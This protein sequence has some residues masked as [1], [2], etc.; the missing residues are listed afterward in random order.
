[1]KKLPNSRPSHLILMALALALSGIHCATNSPTEDLIISGGTIY[2]MD[3]ERPT[4]EAMLIRGGKVVFFGTEAGALTWTGEKAQRININGGIVIPGLIDAHAHVEGVGKLFSQLDLVG[5]SSS[6]EIRD[7]VIEALATTPKGAWLQG[8]GWDQNDWTEKTFPTFADLTETNSHPVYLRRI[9]GHACWVNRRALEICGIDS[10]TQDPP[11]GRIVRDTNGAPTGI[12]VD[13]AIDLISK[14]LENPS[15]AERRNWV[16]TGIREC[17]RLGLVGVHDA[18]V[19]S[20]GLAIY[21]DLAQN[22]SLTLRINAMLSSTETALLDSYLPKGPTTEANGFVNIRSIKIYAD[23][24]LGSRG[25]WLLEPYSDRPELSGLALTAPDSVLALTERAVDAG[26]QV[27]THAIGDRGVRETLDS[28]EETL[29]KT[30]ASD[31]RL[32]I[33][34]SQ[35]ISESDIP[36]FAKLGVIP[37]MQPTHATSDMYWVE[38]RVGPKRIAGAYAWRKLLNSG[39]RIP[40]GS[41]APVESINPLWGIHAAVTRQDHNGWPKDGWHA[42]E[43]LSITE[44]VRGFTIDA[45]YAEFAE[46]ERGALV[47]GKLADITVLDKDIFKISPEQILKTKALYTIIAGKVVYAAE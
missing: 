29:T 26:F 46:D 34:H 20:V 32:R 45:A 4:A 5:T 6:A 33:E 21:R 25:A 16:A 38:E 18:G 10:Q 35:V 27:C 1:M 37:A 44:A 36:R 43:K 22:D 7:L 2:T 31:A 17:N 41:D 14:F 12:F 47:I 3:P 23:G 8:R 11:G 13:N 42:E 28:Y 40:L 24:A 19:D 9:D 39:V 30:G 15:Y